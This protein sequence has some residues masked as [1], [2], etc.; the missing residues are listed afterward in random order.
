MIR[1][2]TPN[3]MPALMDLA[4]ATGMFEANELEGLKGMVSAYFDGHLDDDHFWIVDE[5]EG[6]L[7]GAAYYA[8]ETM[9]YGVWNLYFIGVLPSR[10][11][12]GVGEAL[13]S[14]VEQVLQERSERLL[15]IET[16]SLSEFKNARSFYRKHGYDEEARIRDFYKSGEDK[17]VFRKA[18]TSQ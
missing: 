1:P 18:L 7:R 3:D 4:D 5:V 15:L 17:I 13:L 14:H 16:S 9:T 11:R 12:Q 10:Q 6:A 2:A 8:A